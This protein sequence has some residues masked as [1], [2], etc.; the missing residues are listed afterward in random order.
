MELPQQKNRN[1]CNT[2]INDCCEDLAEEN[3]NNEAEKIMTEEIG[4]VANEVDM[5][6][7][8]GTSQ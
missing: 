5:E 6:V 4:E 7:E 3:S 1:Q 8:Y 2:E